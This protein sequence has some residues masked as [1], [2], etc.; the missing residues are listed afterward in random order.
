MIEIAELHQ[1]NHKITE[2]SNV[3]L[4]LIR[5]RAMCDTEVAGQ[6]LFEYVQRVSEHLDLVDR[7][8]ASRLLTD[9]DPRAQTLARQ[10]VA[11][12][13]FLKKLIGEYAKRWTRKA[14][15]VLFIKDHGSFVRDSSEIIELVLNRIQRETEHLY[16]LW[17][18]YL[19]AG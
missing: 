1:Q 6:L 9:K 15:P 14:K 3:Y 8:M 17:R 5:D 16:P 18:A 19:N 7:Q 12:S 4:Y 10:F 13:S 11:E 2:I